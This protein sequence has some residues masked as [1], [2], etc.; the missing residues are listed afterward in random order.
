MKELI[1]WIRH[2]PPARL[3]C[4]DKCTV[5]IRCDKWR[6]HRSGHAH[7]RYTAE[8]RPIATRWRRI[9]WAERFA[10]GDHPVPR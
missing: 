5:F 6:F 2:H 9:S 4:G 3:R 7:F 10:Y 1:F 8:G